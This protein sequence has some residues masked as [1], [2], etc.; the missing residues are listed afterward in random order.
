[1]ERKD[2]LMKVGM[3]PFCFILFFVLF[4]SLC[5]KISAETFQKNV[6]IKGLVKDL[7][8]YPIIGANILESGTNNGTITN[9]DGEFILTVSN[10]NSVIVVSYIGYKTQEIGINNRDNI[11][12]TLEEDS[13]MFDEVVVI[14]YGTQKKGDVTSSVSSVKSDEFI[15]GSVLDAGQLIQGKVAGLSITTPSGDP[16]ANTQIMLRGITTLKSGTSPLILVDGI[17][18]SLNTIAPEDIESIDVLKDGSAAAIYGSRGTNGVIIITTKRVKGEMAPSIEYN[19]Y[20]NIQSIYKEPEMLMAEDYHRL[21][22]DGVEN[23][24]DLGYETK[25][26][27]KITRTPLSHIHNISLKGG[28]SNT[29]YILTLNYRDM[30]GIFKNTDRN[31]INVRADITHTMFNK[32][33]KLNASLINSVTKYAGFNYSTYRQAIIRNPTDRVYDDEGNYQ[34]RSLFQYANP[35]GL[36]NEYDQKN[37]TRQMRWNLNTTYTP[38]KDFNIKLLLSKVQTSNNYGYSTSF[39]HIDTVRDQLNGTAT[40]SANSSYS[41]YGELTLDYK[42]IREDHIFSALAGYTYEKTGYDDMYMYNYN[43]PSDLYSF[44][45]IGAGNALKEGLATMRSSQNEYKRASFFGRVTY[46]YADRYLFMASLRRDGSSKFGANNKWGIFPAVS[47]GWKINNEK[48]LRDVKVIDEL[49]LRAGFGVTGTEPTDSYMSLTLFTYNGY[50]LN[51]GQWINQLVPSSNPN[52]DLKWERKNEFN[53]GLDYSFYNR[54]ISGSIDYY[55]RRTKDML[56]DYQVPVPPYLY[57][58]ILANAGT[59]DNRGVEVS[60]NVIPVQTSNFEWQSSLNFSKNK[61]TLKSL[62]ND[63]FSTTN[64]Y[65]DIGGTG[66]P[67]QQSTHRVDIGGSI[68]NFYGYKTVDIDDTGAWIIENKDGEL[69]NFGD[70]KASDKQYLGN[71]LPSWYAGWNNTFRYKNWDLNITMRGAFGFQ[72]LN[73]Q[74]MFY[75]NPNIVYNRLKSAFDKVYGK[76]T[77]SVGQEYV[78][79]YIEDGDYWKIDNI[80]LGYTIPLPKSSFIKNARVSLSGMNLLTITG[81]KGLDPEVNR[82]GLTPGIDDRDKYPT[83]RTFTFGLSVTF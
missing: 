52:P 49:K 16:T 48:F 5:T 9:I 78:S 4:S 61:N 60:L 42:L 58:S 26:L 32:K 56:W 63:K 38:I 28:T 80:T 71:G 75:E 82:S 69:V 15:K 2:T 34:E 73:S 54:R 37:E 14:G 27:D 44:N 6:S 25:W 64:S 68:G 76:T 59:M 22:N 17:P 53:F 8:G 19:G 10:S 39:K 7:S 50:I 11:V 67:I 31:S 3:P 79:Y 33:L 21:I 41:N 29:N 36:I 65:F 77:L 40:R 70:R 57:G 1:M 30:Q 83:T 47:L 45:N 13:K 43:F 72:V 66:D 62:S 81:Y 12:I 20:A 35:V 51:N 23:L 46:N 74:R 18:G 55:I 24:T